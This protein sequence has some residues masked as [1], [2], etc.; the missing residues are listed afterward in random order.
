M[1]VGSDGLVEVHGGLR[2]EVEH[3]RGVDRHAQGLV[4]SSID[5]R[6]R[7][8]PQVTEAVTQPAAN[9][10]HQFDVTE[11]V[12]IADK[13]R[14]ALGQLLQQR[15]I[16]PADVAVVHHH[17][18]PH[19]FAHLLHV[20][21]N[22]FLAGFGQVVRQQQ[23]ALGP[24]SLGLL[25]VLDGQP[26]WTTHP[27]KDRHAA[28]AG[29][30]GGLDHGAVLIRSQREEFSRATGREQRGSAIGSQPLQAPGIALGIE[31]AGGIEVGN[32]EGQQAR[33]KDEL[34]FLWSHRMSTLQ[35]NGEG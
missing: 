34:E 8:P 33:G 18:D 12:L 32:R 26:G 25:G 9:G 6:R 19:R 20:S 21:G 1:V 27:G 3:R 22:A 5:L 11:A 31:V 16:Q 23:Q 28:S 2:D 13:V 35:A 17:A 15:G 4:R 14:A 7:Q 29:V 10:N 24:E 30:H